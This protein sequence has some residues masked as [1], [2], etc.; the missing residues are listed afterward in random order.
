M[1]D[2]KKI[3]KVKKFKKVK[4][5]KEPTKKVKK[6][7]RVLKN[8][9][10]I[11]Q[12][13]WIFHRNNP[14]V[15]DMLVYYARQWRAAKGQ[16]SYVGIDLLFC[17]MRWELNISTQRNEDGFKLCD[18]H[19]AYYSRL[20]MDREEDLQGIFR[21]RKTALPASIGPSNESLFPQKP[22]TTI[23]EQE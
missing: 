15:Y 10:P 16:D 7:R 19:R 9:S 14:H 1:E 8:L 20:I 17:R 2:S 18:H 5:V 12:R 22:L 3:R 13:F 23:I 4:R 11:E 6:V 21:L